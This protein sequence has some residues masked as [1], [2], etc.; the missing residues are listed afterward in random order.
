MPSCALTG[1][2]FVGRQCAL[3]LSCP[4]YNA[5]AAD[6]NETFWDWKDEPGGRIMPI[7]A[8]RTG[9]STDGIAI[10]LGPLWRFC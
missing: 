8:L 2:V 4:L 7:R 3:Q 9:I 5:M 6:K 1:V 10:R